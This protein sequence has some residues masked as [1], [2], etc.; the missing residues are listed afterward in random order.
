MRQRALI[1]LGVT[2]GL[3]VLFQFWPQF[4]L[5]ITGWFYQDGAWVW[6]TPLL[7]L[8]R[9][10]YRFG[11]F[12]LAALFVILAL[13][14][15]RGETLVDRRVYSLGAWFSII[16]PGAIVNGI[17]KAY[18]G[19][20]RPANTINFGGEREFTAVSF[21]PVDQCS[22]N[23]SFVSGEGAGAAVMMFVLL[24]MFGTNWRRRLVIIAICLPMGILRIAFGRHFAS[25]VI[26]SFTMMWAL[27]YA[28]MAYFGLTPAMARTRLVEIGG[29][30][31]AM[32][33]STGRAIAGRARRG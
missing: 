21:L 24:L 27:G 19:R 2:L 32:L 29:D 4:D 12:S 6:R 23:C 18:W 9:D 28:L 14:A 26:L 31:R 10:I 5:V 7:D 22:L 3:M 20:A 15:W 11:N 8:L 33:A 1:W 17:F 13:Y 16:G 30:L 25:D